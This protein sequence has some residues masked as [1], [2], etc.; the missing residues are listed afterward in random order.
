MA[1]VSVPGNP[2]CSAGRRASSAVLSTAAVLS[3]PY[4]SLSL[5]LLLLL[6]R[7]KGGTGSRTGLPSGATTIAGSPSSSAPS[8]VAC[9][10][11]IAP[12]TSV[13]FR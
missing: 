12:V 5:G 3:H 10:R 1:A 7:L 11:E 4:L 8:T 2:S 9:S 13:G 6:A